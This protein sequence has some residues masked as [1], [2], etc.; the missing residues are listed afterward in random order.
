MV[1]KLTFDRVEVMREAL[2]NYRDEKEY[3][4]CRV[5]IHGLPACKAMREDVIIANK[6]IKELEVGNHARPTK[7]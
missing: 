5:N 7:K 1:I 2:V 6:L 3:Q 4:G